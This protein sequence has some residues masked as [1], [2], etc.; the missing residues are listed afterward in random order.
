MLAILYGEEEAYTIWFLTGY[1]Y[2]AEFKDGYT[3]TGSYS[4]KDGILTLTAK[5][6][7]KRTADENWNMAFGDELTAEIVKADF[8][9]SVKVIGEF[10]LNDDSVLE[11]TDDK[12]EALDLGVISSSIDNPQAFDILKAILPEEA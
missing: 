3:E 1:A 10:N 8:S 11:I 12:Q 9:D 2:K 5:D 7:S 4:V 6:G